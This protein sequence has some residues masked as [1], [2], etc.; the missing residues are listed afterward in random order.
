MQRVQSLKAE[1][2]VLEL[3]AAS[4]IPISTQLYPTQRA[5]FSTSPTMLQAQLRG[6]V[7]TAVNQLVAIHNEAARQE[8]GKDRFASVPSEYKDVEGFVEM[9]ESIMP[10]PKQ[11]IQSSASKAIMIVTNPGF[12]WDA[13]PKQRSLPRATL[14]LL[15]G[16]GLPLSRQS[17]RLIKPSAPAKP[18]GIQGRAQTQT[19]LD[20]PIK[21]S[22]DALLAARAL[23]GFNA[24]SSAD[25]LKAVKIYGSPDTRDPLS[26]SVG[27]SLL[28]AAQSEG[29]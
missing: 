29:T 27:E 16:D 28:Q 8:M 20:T 7:S 5:V 14:I 15:G 23:H 2:A 6:P 24:L 4:G 1:M 9:I 12:D 18:A 3:F 21:L 17:V 26:F 19:R 25:R 13:P 10:P 11:M 22:A